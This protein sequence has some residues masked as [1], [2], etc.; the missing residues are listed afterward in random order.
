MANVYLGLAACL[1]GGVAVYVWQRY[2]ASKE[3][4]ELGRLRDEAEQG[5]INAER[6]KSNAEV[7]LKG[8]C[9]EIERQ[10]REAEENLNRQ[11]A[12]YIGQIDDL[13]SKLEAAQKKHDGA[14]H[15]V[16]RLNSAQAES[17]VAL[18]AE[19]KRIVDMQKH[20]E[21]VLAQMKNEF[22]ALS[23]DVLKEKR[24]QLEKEG[25]AGVESITEKLRKEIESFRTRVESVNKDDIERTASLKKEIEH[26]VS[27]TNLVSAEA[28]K[29]A[30]AIRAEASVTGQWGEIQLM[31]VLELGGLQQTVDYEYQETFA[32]PGSTRVDLRTDVLVKMPDERWVVIDAKT[33]MA[34]YADYAGEE[35]VRNAEAV[36]RIV[37]SLVEHVKEMKK[38][39]YHKK[40]EATTGKRI[41]Q[42]M[43]MY[44]PFEEVYL[45]AMKAT[46]DGPNGKT[47]LREWA[48]KNDIVFVNASGLI[49]IV[50]MLAD[51]WARNRSEKKVL[52]IK[53]AAESLIE[54][55]KTFIEGAGSR[56]DGFMTIGAGLAQAVNAYNESIKRLSDGRGA[57][58]KKLIELKEMGVTAADKLPPPEQVFTRQ[59]D[60]PAAAPEV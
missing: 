27:Q 37:N 7:A 54:K 4:A 50:R 18:E 12:Q 26:L 60:A 52:Q 1:V 13:N 57:V 29:L 45:M 6:E 3:R 21:T 5:R 47:P 20:Y 19:K 59:I 38:V 28:D 2:A 11:S 9:E 33:T 53:D 17:R 41:L 44:I 32:S 22:K 15:E 34:A 55:F 24:E 39:E 48:W 16:S 43:L 35:G 36:K 46:V 23:D 40:L 31:R 8:K 49:P 42:T 30:T 25:L 10:R 56:K 14:M 51:L 58:M